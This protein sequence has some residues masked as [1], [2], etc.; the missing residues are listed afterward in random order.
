MRLI[1]PLQGVVQG[2]GGLI[3]G[4]FIPCTLFYLLQLYLKRNRRPPTHLDPTPSTTD[5]TRT[6]SR[7]SLGPVQVSLRAESIANPNPSAYYVGWSKYLEDPYD[8]LANPDGIIQLGLSENRL[9]FDLIEKWMVDNLESVMVGGVGGISRIDEMLLYQPSDGMLEMKKAMANF[10]SLVMRTTTPFNPSHL[11]LTSGATAAIE[12]LSFCL[13]DQGNGLL[14]PTPYYP[15]FDRDVIWRA[16]V[17]LIHVHCCSSDNFSP[18]IDAFEQAY[19]NARRHGIKVRGVLISN[20]SNPV[21]N[22]LSKEFLYSLLDFAKNKNIHIISDEIYAGSVYGDE[23]FVSMAEIVGSTDTDKQRV[24]IVY[25]ISKDLSL[26]GFR[27]G[28]VH[29]FNETVLTATKRL[30][31]F[32]TVSS[33]TQRIMISM[34]SDSSF[35]EEYMMTNK[36]RLKKMHQLLV[37]SLRLSGIKCNESTAGFYCWVD[38]RHLLG[39][40]SEKGEL[41]LWHNLLNVAKINTTPGTSCHCVEPG[42][43]RCCFANLDEGDIPVILDRILRV[44]NL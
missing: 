32:T 27:I 28:V 25:G 26:P 23:E 24:H 12:M 37:S 3:L 5:L 35:I 1:V 9:S 43:F 15:G 10:M 42:W 36:D 11:V 33:P 20:P 30:A 22:I 39:S 19:R 2:R 38:I 7:S 21:G 17:E 29:S 16:G 34:L 44:V 40:S 41:E 14:V 8:R 31:R 4:S 18:S 13:A 6:S